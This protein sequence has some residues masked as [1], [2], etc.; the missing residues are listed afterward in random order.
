MQCPCA[1]GNYPISQ[2]AK[3][4]A[5]KDQCSIQA[6]LWPW[7]ICID[8][9]WWTC[10]DQLW[11]HDLIYIVEQ[12]TFVW[13]RIPFQTS[14]LEQSRTFEDQSMR[15]GSSHIFQCYFLEAWSLDSNWDGMQYG[16]LWMYKVGTML[17][18]HFEGMK[19]LQ[20]NH[21]MTEACPGL[22]RERKSCWGIPMGDLVSK[23]PLRALGTLMPSGDPNPQDYNDARKPVSN[24]SHKCNLNECNFTFYTIST[25]LISLYGS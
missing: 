13:I 15:S 6:T 11:W 8:H 21:Y 16:H 12:N 3:F 5:F 22:L 4:N 1:W 10:V 2:S 17:D 9:A 25:N 14:I 18:H 24:P 7:A 20:N 19:Q 23:S